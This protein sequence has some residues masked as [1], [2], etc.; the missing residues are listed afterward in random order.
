MKF[1]SHKKNGNNFEK[2][3]KTIALNVVFVSYN[4][5]QIETAYISK[6]NSDRENQVILLMIADGEK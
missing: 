4:T 3:N 1:P 6:H 5:K 2:N